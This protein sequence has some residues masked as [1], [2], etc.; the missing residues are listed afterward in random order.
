M[1]PPWVPPSEPGGL[2][3]IRTATLIPS[4]PP[5]SRMTSLNPPGHPNHL[6]RFFKVHMTNFCAITTPSR[7][8]SPRAAWGLGVC[9]LIRCPDD[10]DSL[11]F[12][13]TLTYP[14]SSGSSPG[15]W[16]T[17]SPALLPPPTLR[18]C[19]SVPAVARAGPAQCRGWEAFL[20]L[21]IGGARDTEMSSEI[22]PK[23]SMT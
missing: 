13:E 16:L 23:Y 7:S 22:I 17:C 6:G 3:I 2:P 4:I 11:R 9:T 8:W 14:K 12:Q 5:S 21:H 15:P 10:P 20:T 18:A 1:D 19:F